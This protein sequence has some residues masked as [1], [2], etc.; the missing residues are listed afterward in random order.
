VAAANRRV[1][2]P[3]RCQSQQIIQAQHNANGGLDCAASPGR[4]SFLAAPAGQNHICSQVCQSPPL[5]GS[6]APRP[7]RNHRRRHRV[8]GKSGHN[9]GSAPRVNSGRPDIGGSAC[10]RHAPVPVYFAAVTA[11]R[12][13]A[14]CPADSGQA[15][16]LVVRPGGVIRNRYGRFLMLQLW[17]LVAKS[18]SVCLQWT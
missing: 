4:C 6:T 14:Q 3:A 12:K 18:Q 16:W 2:C 5:A 13:P 8:A 1:G 7:R 15:L 10:V 17:F 9:Y 11:C